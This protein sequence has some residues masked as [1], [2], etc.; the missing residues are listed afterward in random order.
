MAANQA[1]HAVSEAMNMG[2]PYLS[3]AFIHLNQI[4]DIIK[5]PNIT[6][7][8]TGFNSETLSSQERIQA[9]QELYSSIQ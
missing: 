5:N 8:A 1:F 2:E 3:I 9:I 4:S 7:F 6:V